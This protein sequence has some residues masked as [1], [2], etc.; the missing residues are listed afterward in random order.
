M[1][2][3]ADANRTQVQDTRNHVINTACDF[4]I[5]FFFRK[6]QSNNV[7]F[8]GIVCLAI[9]LI[10]CNPVRMDVHGTPISHQV[11]KALK[12]SDESLNAKVL[13]C[14]IIYSGLTYNS[15][16]LSTQFSSSH[17]AVGD[18]VLVVVMP[19]TKL[20]AKQKQIFSS[21]TVIRQLL[22]LFTMRERTLVLQSNQVAQQMN[23]SILSLKNTNT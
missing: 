12:E 13:I 14:A 20:H 15:L 18:C 19:L 3:L 22:S 21:R 23:M 10:L 5:Y 2:S 6:N 1:H 9:K 11:E 4:S 17:L 7:H 16:R 8:V